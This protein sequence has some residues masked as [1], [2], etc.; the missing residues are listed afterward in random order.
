MSQNLFCCDLRAFVWRKIE[1]EIVL[2]EKIR[3]ISGMDGADDGVD[4]EDEADDD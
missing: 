4:N 1:P 3:Q 2:V